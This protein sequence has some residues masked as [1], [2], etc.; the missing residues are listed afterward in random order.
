L[1]RT[2]ALAHRNDRPLPRPARALAIELA[3]SRGAVPTGR[4]TDG[5]TDGTTDGATDGTDGDAE[6]APARG[7]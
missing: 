7:V 2:V 5:A 6:S 4:S 1:S 3:G